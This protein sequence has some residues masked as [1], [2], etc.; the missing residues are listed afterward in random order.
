V[1][2]GSSEKKQIGSRVLVTFLKGLGPSEEK[3]KHRKKPRNETCMDAFEEEGAAAFW[4][5]DSKGKEGRFVVKEED[6]K[7]L[8]GKSDRRLDWKR[9]LS[10]SLATSQE[11]LSPEL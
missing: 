1:Q 6:G 4:R 3:K 7:R 8:K 11:K 5:K 9:V 2:R 10:K